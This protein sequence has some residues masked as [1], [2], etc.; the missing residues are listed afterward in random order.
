VVNRA[1]SYRHN[2]DRHALLKQYPPSSPGWW[3]RLMEKCPLR[4]KR[5]WPRGPPPLGFPDHALQ[6]AFPRR[7]E[8]PTQVLAVS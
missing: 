2:E 6:P 8:P 7:S 4:I 5:Y 1:R 3:T